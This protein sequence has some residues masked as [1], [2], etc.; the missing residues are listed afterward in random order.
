[1]LYSQ[2]ATPLRRRRSRGGCALCRQGT[3]T[4]SR[5][6]REKGAAPV[7]WPTA[8]RARGQCAGRVPALTT[9][10]LAKPSG[11]H[12]PCVGPRVAEAEGTICGGRSQHHESRDNLPIPFLSLGR[13]ARL[14]R[15]GP[16]ALDASAVPAPMPAYLCT[17]LAL[18]QLTPAITAPPAGGGKGRQHGHRPH[19]RATI[20]HK[21][22]WINAQMYIDKHN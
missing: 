8:G 5:G 15:A 11:C 21:Y 3:I 16:T 10:D 20:N 19:S 14:P 2:P 4:A 9:D 17:H 18:F 7:S 13:A 1:M 6:G 12:Q 22:L